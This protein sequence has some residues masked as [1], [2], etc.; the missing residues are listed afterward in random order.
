MAFSLKATEDQIPVIK[1]TVLKTVGEL[2]ELHVA[3]T[4]PGVAFL[5]GQKIPADLESFS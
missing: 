4:N 1:E 5:Q 2:A 3:T